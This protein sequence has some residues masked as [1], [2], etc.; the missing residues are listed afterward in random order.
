MSSFLTESIEVID[1]TGT[2][3]HRL[4]PID[5]LLGHADRAGESV[6]AHVHPDDLPR[7]LEFGAAV[8]ESDPGWHGSIP[9]R[10]CDVSGRWHPYGIEVTNCLDDPLLDGIVARTRALPADPSEVDAATRRL[11]RVNMTESIVEAV[12]VAL[13]VLD[14][15]GRMEFANHAARLL[16]DL[17]DGP[18]RGRYLPDVAVERDRAEVSRSVELLLHRLGTRTVV[19]DTRGW[20]G[21]GDRRQIEARLQARGMADRPSTIIVTLD[22]VTV[23]RREEADLRRRATLDPLTG[24]LNRAALLD[25]I[26]ARL[27][28][29]PL[30]AIYGDLDGFKLVN[31]TFG[32][33]G[34][35]NVLMEVARILRSTS[36]PNDAVGR[37]GGDE[38]V[39]VRD[40]RV[41]AQTADLV[42]RLRA[43]LEQGPGIRMSIGTAD[44]DANSSADD[45]LARADRAMYEDKGSAGGHSVVRRRG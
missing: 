13:M 30:T 32:H 6:F 5:G 35:D 19:F 9:V 1:R 33:A 15:H 16:C 4:G 21:R 7:V 39:I 17:P 3:R 20:R 28:R 37:F 31:D 10:L 24:L 44:T 11:S 43:A 42:G 34:G 12:P 22:D 25:E 8:L 40:G 27:A 2:V 41:T 45:L 29:G 23:R 38:F 26:E 18:I 14:R 36:G